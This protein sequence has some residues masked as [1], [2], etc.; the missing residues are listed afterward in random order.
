[1]GAP[2]PPPTKDGDALLFTLSGDDAASFKTDNNGQITTK[3]KLDFE[4][5]DTYMV[6]LTATDPSGANDSIMVTVM[7]TDGNDNAVITGSTAVDYDENGTGPVATFS[8]TDQDGDDIVWSLG[9][10]D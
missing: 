9:G 10:T 8:A 6:M 1:M 3:V 5:K 7:V 2:S 4:T